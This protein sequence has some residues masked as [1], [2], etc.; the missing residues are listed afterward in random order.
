MKPTLFIVGAPKCGTTALATYLG[1][2]PDIWMSIPKEPH[3]FADDFP[4]Y[5]KQCPSLDFYESL[6][7]GANTQKKRLAGE[8]SVWYQY[9]QNAISNIKRYNP[10]AKLIVMLRR[11]ADVVTSLHRQL[12]FTLDEDEQDLATALQKMKDRKNG[13]SIPTT[14]REPKFLQYMDVV[15]FGEQ[16]ARIYDVF[17]SGQVKVILFDD[18]IQH[19]DKVYRDVLSFLSIEDDGRTDFP[20]VNERK[21]SR[22]RMLAK[23]LSRPPLPVSKLARAVKKVVPVRRLGVLQKLQA[24][25]SKKIEQK[26][27]LKVEERVWEELQ[28]DIGLLED[29]LS[30]SLSGWCRTRSDTAAGAVHE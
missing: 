7:S 21:E 28:S 23:L 6:F 19:T 5:K 15:H 26:V 12:L 11:P 1:E 14:C 17:N 10:S 2:H 9:S 16:L 24:L 13:Q 22:N 27:D 29:M 25:N 8:A 3:F 18:F 4:H 20:S 30:C